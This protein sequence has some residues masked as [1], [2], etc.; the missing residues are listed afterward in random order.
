[1]SVRETITRNT[2]FNTLGRLW[3][4]VAGVVL[5]YYIYHM[6]G[7]E[8]YGLWA[9][10][11]AFTGYATLLDV[12]VS[13]AFTK[14]IAQYAATDDHDGVSSVINT[15]LLF[16]IL[17]GGAIA[18]VGWPLITY[19]IDAAIWLLESM[20]PDHGGRYR[21]VGAVAE[22]QYLCRCALLLFIL[23]NCLAPVTAIQ[24][25]FQRMGISNILSFIA[26]IAKLVLTV[27]FLQA[28]YGVRGLLYTNGLVLLLLALLSL[29]V[30][31]K[32]FP[33]LRF[34]PRHINRAV[35]HDLY[36]FGWR[37]QVAKLA[38]IINF[39]TDRIVIGLVFGDLTWVGIYRAGEELA[40]K[41]RQ[42][43]ALVVS[44]LIPAV[45]DLEAREKHDT[46]AE[47]YARSTKYI[48]LVTVPLTVFSIIF[49]M[50]LLRIVFADAANLHTSAWVLRIILMGYLANVLPGPGVSI[51]LGK[52]R[53]DLPMYAG[54]ISMT[55]NILLTLLLVYTMGFL[56]VPM[57]T[58]LAMALSTL[59][60]MN[61]MITIQPVSR[62]R[63]LREGLL[64][65]TIICIP[66]ALLTLLMIFAIQDIDSRLEN[67][68][69]S[70]VGAALFGLVYVIVMR[71][72]RVLDAFDVTFME[73]SLH[74]NRL[75]LFRWWTKRMRHV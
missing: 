70:G 57:A 29:A 59:W 14:Y 13:S 61:A 12:G 1:M 30:G 21:E 53:A 28:G 32:I 66:G 55:A 67:F 39:Q 40:G 51:A 35:L 72:S 38:N 16:Y 22:V 25:G 6:L 9:L 3:E 54:L 5:T 69:L 44:A 34:A 31:F 49:A 45:S 24:S 10:V 11:G 73:E 63:L 52:G 48:A 2:L 8:G 37:S 62:W 64:L 19:L 41:L 26:S 4:A 68:I 33:A 15:G 20:H 56:G 17:L 7:W 36:Q 65:P 43:P 27:L 18:V 50:P 58:A 60:F 47:L 75:P 71:W 23:G 74:L 42:I 46:I